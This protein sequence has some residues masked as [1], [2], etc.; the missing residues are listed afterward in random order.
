MGLAESSV[1]DTD[2][3]VEVTSRSP[4]SSRARRIPHAVFRLSV[5]G[6]STEA[7]QTSITKRKKLERPLGKSVVMPFLLAHAQR[8]GW[9]VGKAPYTVACVERVEIYGLGVELS[10][11]TRQWA[12]GDAPVSV[13][14]FLRPDG[15]SDQLGVLSR[16][17]RSL[18]ES[19][20]LSLTP[21]R[22]HSNRH[23]I[24]PVLIAEGEAVH[25]HASF[26][27]DATDASGQMATEL[28]DDDSWAMA[29]APVP[30]SVPATALGGTPVD[31]PPAYGA[32]HAGI[33][34]DPFPES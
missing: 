12:Q 19:S 13:V 5:A 24:G 22:S 11:P 28:D 32:V 16:W 1:D 30:A 21:R 15:D 34:I 29:F 18:L 17:F 3:P 25:E 33:L 20:A 6:E 26:R 23:V 2:A 4:R 27:S 14:V 8:V 7:L 10:W 9:P 31:A